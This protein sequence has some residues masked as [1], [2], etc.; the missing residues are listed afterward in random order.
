VVMVS[1][2]PPVTPSVP[3]A[4]LS[5]FVESGVVCEGKTATKP[6]GIRKSRRFSLHCRGVRG[7]VA[8]LVRALHS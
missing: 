6:V 5:S 8:Q 4:T 1:P 3:L 2:V 7:A